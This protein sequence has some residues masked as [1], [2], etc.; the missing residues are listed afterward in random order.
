MKTTIHGWLLAIVA[1]CFFHTAAAAGPLTVGCDTDFKPFCFRDANGNIT[2]FDVDLWD[3]VAQR[4]GVEYRLVPMTFSK[5]I[6]ALVQHEIDTALAG[7]TIT[8]ERERKIDFA[9]P[10]YSSGLLV[11]VRAGRKGIDGIGDLDDK[12]VATKKGT[13]SESFVKNIQTRDLR[14]V[15]T[16]EDAYAELLSGRA[17]AVV[18]DSPALLHFISEGNEGRV[19]V[20]GPLYHR[21]AYGFGFPP[22]SKTAEK[23]SVALLELMESGEYTRIY[24]RWFGTFPF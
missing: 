3:A 19:K 5:L 7:I 9:F 14:L 12:V 10:Y 6:P 8:A 18:F 17:D 15:A 23:V 20:V 22:G 24:R 4:M 11:M 1:L 2:G 21:S 16:I 13:T